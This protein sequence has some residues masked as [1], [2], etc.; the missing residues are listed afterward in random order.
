LLKTL[1]QVRMAKDYEQEEAVNDA[2]NRRAKEYEGLLFSG[3]YSNWWWELGRRMHRN[4]DTKS[5]MIRNA[6]NAYNSMRKEVGL[7]EITDWS[8]RPKEFI[9]HMDSK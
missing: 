5:K 8:K 3:A 7:P 4:Q 2:F 9:Q 6:R 1:A